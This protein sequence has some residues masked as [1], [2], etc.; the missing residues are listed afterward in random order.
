MRPCSCPFHLPVRENGWPS[1]SSRFPAQTPWGMRVPGLHPSR[2]GSVSRRRLGNL[3]FLTPTQSIFPQALRRA[4]QARH[5]G[6]VCSAALSN[7][8]RMILGP[9]LPL[10]SL[11]ALV[12]KMGA[13]TVSVCGAAMTVTGECQKTPWHWPRGNTG[14]GLPGR[15]SILSQYGV[16]VCVPACMHVTLCVSQVLVAICS[17]AGWASG[18]VWEARVGHRAHPRPLGSY[19]PE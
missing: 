12:C 10:L 16:C 4:G 17:G 3:L 19:I 18:H 2:S 7:P 8:G 14:C 5:H 6:P 15:G 9:D 1:W 11:S 13:E